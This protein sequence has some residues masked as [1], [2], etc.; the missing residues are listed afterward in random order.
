MK[1]HR[2]S[3]RGTIRGLCSGVLFASDAFLRGRV[4]MGTA[5]L[6]VR[7]AFG[8]VS[9]FAAVAEPCGR[10]TATGRCEG[11]ARPDQFGTPVSGSFRFSRHT[12]LVRRDSS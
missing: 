8:P 2:P 1:G 11:A 6:Y 9:L 7:L 3:Y 10:A 5:M 12:V 4:G